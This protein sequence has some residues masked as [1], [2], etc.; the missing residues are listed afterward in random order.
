M[1]IDLVQPLRA[2]RLS[3]SAQAQHYLRSLIEKG[4]YRPGD[5]LPS[6][7][8]LAAQLG[9][10]RP[11]LREALLNLEQ[12]GVIVLRH[13]VGTFVAP[14]AGRRLESGLER[15]E[16]IS[17]LA[18]R[19][20]LEVQHGALDVQ[21][22]AASADLAATLKVPEATLLTS[23]Q[24]VILADQTPVAYMLD[25]VPT[26]LLAP[27][28]LGQAFKGSVLD[29]LRQQQGLQVAQASAEIVAINA[30]EALADRLQVE[31]GQAIL[32]IEEILY[33]GAAVPV[34]FSRNY[35][36]PEFFQ[37]QVIRR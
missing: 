9:I 34:G 37:F 35:F 20:G 10:S 4:A 7:A 24:R 2:R 15:L 19:Q 31:P 5:Q 13:G 18:R 30:D 17:E 32:L 11:T 14:G 27:T 6:Q 28:D 1:T 33:N 29:L 21:V 36:V 23:I 3:L 12:D 22:I 26:S 25:V 16:S 8:E